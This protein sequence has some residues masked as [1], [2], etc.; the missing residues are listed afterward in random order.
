[1]RILRG[2]C[3]VAAAITAASCAQII[4]TPVKAPTKDA[5]GVISPAT[6]TSSDGII[7][8]LPKTVVRV[9]FK[10]DQIK[11][12]GAPYA[13]FSAI[14][15]PAGE[16]VCADAQCTDDEK[17][18]FKLQDGMIFSTIGEPDPA[19]VYLVKFTGGGTIDHKMTMAWN[20]DGLI[21]GTAATVTNRSADVA[22][23][24]VKLLSSLYAKG[25]FGAASIVGPPKVQECEQTPS[26]I[27]HWVIPVIRTNAPGANESTEL[28][29]NYC[30]MKVED[31]KKLGSGSASDQDLLAKATA[32]FVDKI[33]PL[34][35]SRASALTNPQTLQPGELIDRIDGEITQLFT[36]FYLGKE[37]TKT[38]DG[39]LEA[40][41][42]G[43]RVTNQTTKKEDYRKV[44]SLLKFD[45]KK[46]IC[47]VDD[48]TL[49]IGAKPIPKGFSVDANGECAVGAAVLLHWKHWPKE[50]DQLASMIVDDNEGNRSFRYRMPAQVEIWVENAAKEKLGAA[51][52][53]IAQLGPV[54]SLPGGRKL[55]SI[56]YDLT[57]IESTGALKVFKLDST[58]GFDA[59][60]VDSL[61]TAAGS[62]QDADNARAAKRKAAQD[63]Q[64][65][66]QDELTILTREAALLK[67]RDDI[68]TLRKK[69]GQTCDDVAP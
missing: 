44:A 51:T 52:L 16:R 6:T 30:A 11:R 66:A 3:L 53:R 69:S 65:L 49:P 24:G 67:L 36:E 19:R 63:A 34:K 17:L 64:D 15:I 35:L 22:M 23:S 20:D 43:Q 10:M 5:Q 2:A 54:L 62:I 60:T 7:Y 42:I 48:A 68:C 55:K 40:R 13:R 27:D 8:A 31:R 46:G 26:D 32:L 61:S 58:G 12:T 57:F 29:A 50:E 1:M 21:S 25:T 9:Q 47:L 41:W 45:K 39:T 18:E 59:G 14:F 4:V 28:L 33:V 37:A 56:N 38:W